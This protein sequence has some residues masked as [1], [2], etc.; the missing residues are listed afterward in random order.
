MFLRHFEQLR[1]RPVLQ[2]RVLGI[3]RHPHLSSLPPGR[4]GC[5]CSYAPP[6]TI[7]PDEIRNAILPRF[8]FPSFCHS[9]LQCFGMIAVVR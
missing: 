8:Y 6:V 4:H 3:V 2:Q 7:N 1:R 9:F 5:P